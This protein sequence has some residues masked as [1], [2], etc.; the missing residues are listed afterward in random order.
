MSIGIF[1]VA[2][3]ED[4]F[5]NLLLACSSPFPLSS[6]KSSWK[7]LKMGF[8][9]QISENNVSLCA[10]HNKLTLT[11]YLCPVCSA[12]NCHL[13][14]DCAICGMTLVSPSH[15]ARSY[16]YLFPMSDY[17]KVN[18]SADASFAAMQCFACSLPLIQKGSID[19]EALANKCK[20]CSAIFCSPCD[21]FIHTSLH[22]CP[23]CL[24]SVI[25]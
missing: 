10:C 14:C 12:K 7:L 25:L 20:K 24:C 21:R 11:G 19:F 1:S 16:H 9:K 18:I 2:L 6:S 15:L 13:P 4:H 22:D 17:E 23:N 3:N 5:N 8:P